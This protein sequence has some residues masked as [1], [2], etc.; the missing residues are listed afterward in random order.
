MGILINLSGWIYFN[1]RTGLAQWLKSPHWAKRS[2]VRVSLSAC[3]G[4]A[5]L[6]YSFPRPHSR[7]SYQ[8]WVCPFFLEQW[9]FTEDIWTKLEKHVQVICER[10]P[11]CLDWRL[12]W[13]GWLSPLCQDD[14]RNWRAGTGIHIADVSLF[15]PDVDL[16][17]YLMLIFL[18][19]SGETEDTFIADLAVGL[20]TVRLE[21]GYI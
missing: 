13:P 18:F 6:G 12:I 10:V 16:V 20:A 2:W 3:R 7:G 19:I 4:K 5:C 8:H 15:L 1:W 11:H 9:W 17:W 21:S 14:W